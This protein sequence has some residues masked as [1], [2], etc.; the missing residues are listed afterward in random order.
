MIASASEPLRDFLI[1]NSTEFTMRLCTL[2][3]GGG[4]QLIPYARLR[5]GPG[6][7]AHRVGLYYAQRLVVGPWLRRSIAGTIASL[8]RLG[9]STDSWEPVGREYASVVS[10]LH[11]Q[12]IS[13]LDNF[14]NE[15]KIESILKYLLSQDVL[16]ADKRLVP[17]DQ[18]PPDTRI[19]VY[20]LQTLIRNTE[21]LSLI[22][23]APVLRIAAD[24]LGCKPTLSGLGAY[25][26]FPGNEPAVY[27]QHFHRDL[28]DWR[29]VKLFVYLT[30]VDHGSG[31]HAYVMQS[32]RTAAHFRARQYSRRAIDSRYGRDKVHTVLGPRGTAFMAD[33]YGIHAGTVPTHAPRL[34]LQAQYSL[35]P[36]FA[37]YYEPVETEDISDLD[38]Y[39][40]RLIIARDSSQPARV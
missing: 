15:D 17:M 8:I 7:Q 10:T 1:D 3:E 22:N 23:A 12:G 40:T 20:P 38:S 13:R 16:L 25:W 2:G 11:Q 39:V 5:P 36:V 37:F 24:Y 21:V 6:F 28:D 30:D 26:S 35:L 19:A 27:T 31:P 14:V 32:H 34:V 29:F 9:Q 18:L 33:T 4:K